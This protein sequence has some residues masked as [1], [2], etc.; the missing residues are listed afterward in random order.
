VVDEEFRGDYEGV[1]REYWKLVKKQ[2][3]RASTKE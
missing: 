3:R 2:R 1:L